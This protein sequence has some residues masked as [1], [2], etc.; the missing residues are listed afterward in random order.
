MLATALR[1]EA[2]INTFNTNLSFVQTNHDIVR[3]GDDAIS[4]NDL[5]LD[6]PEVTN[7]LI[8]TDGYYEELVDE[9]NC[10]DTLQDCNLMPNGDNIINI[11]LINVEKDVVDQQDNVEIE[12]VTDVILKQNGSINETD[13]EAEFQAKAN[14]NTFNTNLSFVQTNHDIVRDGDDAIS[15]NDLILDIPEVTNYLIET[16]GYYEELVDENNC[17]D[18]LQDC[19]LM[20][21]G[22]NIINIDLINVE[23]DVVDQQDN[24][25]IEDVTDVILKQNGNRVSDIQRIRIQL[26]NARQDAARDDIISLDPE[27]MDPSIS[28]TL[29]PAASNELNVFTSGN[30]TVIRKLGRSGVRQFMTKNDILVVFPFLFLS[31]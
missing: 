9:N 24:V 14:I 16:D 23:K 19:N 26:E 30:E 13:R 20:P 7:Y 6:I 12:D 17:D 1:T 18:T 25:E 15:G 27:L 4:G 3:D 2:N 29:I 10:D 31:L 22:D 21:N 11:D 5:I 28:L 8:E